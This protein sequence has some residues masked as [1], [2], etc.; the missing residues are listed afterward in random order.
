MAG[1]FNKRL[2]SKDNVNRTVSITTLV[3]NVENYIYRTMPFGMD[4]IYYNIGT[5]AV[6][7]RINRKDD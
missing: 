5:L 2:N 1:Q 6:A 7:V 3:W 4:Q